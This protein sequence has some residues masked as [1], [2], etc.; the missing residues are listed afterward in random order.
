MG[1]A[2]IDPVAVLACTDALTGRQKLVPTEDDSAL[3]IGTTI[4]PALRARGGVTIVG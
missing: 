4:C 1:V 3:T 2:E